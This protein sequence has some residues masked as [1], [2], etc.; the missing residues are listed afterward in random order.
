MNL[1]EPPII[2]SFAPIEKQQ[3][4]TP[5]GD[6]P[7]DRPSSD[8]PSPKRPA[9]LPRCRPVRRHWR[10]IAAAVLLALIIPTGWSYAGYL[11]APG[12][13]PTDVRSIEWLRDH[14]LESPVALAEQWWYTRA[15]PSGTT[16]PVSDLVRSQPVSVGA[17]L[18]T[19]RRVSLG[20]TTPVPE[21]IPVV[22]GTP[23]AGEGVWQPVDG[24]ASNGGVDQMFIRPDPTY[25]AVA[26]NLVRFDQ[27]KISLIYAPGTAEPKGANWAWNS[28]IPVSQRTHAVAAFNAGFKFKDTAGGVYTEG[29]SA[30]RPLEDGLASV[31]IR[32]DGTADIVKWGRDATTGPNISTVRQNLALIVDS[33]QPV[34]GLASSTGGRWGSRQ[35]QL[36][37][38]SRSGLGID[39]HGR[40]LYAAGAQMSLSELAAALSDAGAVRAM[41]L[42]IHKQMVSFSWYRQDLSSSTGVQATKLIESMRR[43][44]TRY[45]SPDQRDFFTV[46][47]R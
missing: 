9:R 24:L 37:F 35:S 19:G 10:R 26:V 22:V 30:V 36:Q 5:E 18:G 17:T 40:L 28:Q 44:A 29:R 31:V 33:A 11:T 3:E 47:A 13:A 39:A 16:A 46:I 27:R 1:N 43:D 6:A 21:T 15:R 23:Q 8:T 7:P 41:Q 42:D 32:S 2:E 12:D 45:L 25:P 4:P 34:T 14:G 20:G 38:T